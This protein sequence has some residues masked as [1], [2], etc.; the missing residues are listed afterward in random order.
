MLYREKNAVAKFIK[1]IFKE[2][3]YCKNVIKKHLKNLVMNA[4][5]NELFERTNTCWIYG[6]LIDLDN[7]VRD[8]YHITG[9]YTGNCAHW[10]CNINLKITKKVPGIFHNLKGYASHLIFKE[11]S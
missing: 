3:D 6:K 5:E 4:K 7:K 11:L 2:Y 10:N 8:H 1:S 9:K